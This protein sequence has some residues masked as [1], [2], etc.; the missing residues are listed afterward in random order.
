MP[1]RRNSKEFTVM[2]SLA[3]V[4]AMIALVA[5]SVPLYQLFCRATGYGGTVQTT[6][7]AHDGQTERVVT[8]R[9]DTTV[10]S[11]LPWRFR[12]AQPQ[13]AVHLGE[14]VLA[15]FTAE[16]TSAE[17]VTGQATFNVTPA[18]AGPYFNKIE[19][20]CFTEQI[21]NPGQ[22]VDMPVAFYV[23]PALA[24]DPHT[25]EITTITLSYTFFRAK[26]SPAGNA[27]ET[28]PQGGR[29]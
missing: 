14:N 25:E 20:F 23:D 4:A 2:A 9:F 24:S 27:Q 28:K 15:Y 19:C 1:L 12:P 16:N 3:A 17:P 21:L 7:T 13:M 11:A 26:D 22:R 18:K 6:S 5:V 8:V 10:N 29:S